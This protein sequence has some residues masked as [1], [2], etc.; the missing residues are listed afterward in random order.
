MVFKK[1]LNDLL[2]RLAHV[3]N[4]VRIG[5]VNLTGSGSFS[6]HRVGG[7]VAIEV[8][9]RDQASIYSLIIKVAIDL[10]N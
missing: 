4:A 10:N 6:R 5:M 1:V 2:G 7:Y 3:A 9:L 8:R